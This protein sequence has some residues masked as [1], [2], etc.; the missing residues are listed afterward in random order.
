MAA[1]DKPV[2]SVVVAIVSDTTDRPDVTHL[3]PCLE[4][5]TKQAAQRPM[6][7]IVP[8]HPSVDGIDRMRLKYPDVRFVEAA[9]LTT[10]TGQGGSRE[11]HDELRARGLAAARGKIVA[12]IEDHGIVAPDWSARVL[13]AHAH[14]FAAIGGAI[15]NGIDQPL[16]WAVYFC[17]FLRYQ[18]PLPEGASAMAS[19]ANVSYKRAALESIQPVWKQIFHES[20]VNQALWARGEKIALAPRMVLEQHRLGLRMGAAMKERYVW[21]RSYAA[22]RARLAL[23]PSA[24]SGPSFRPCFRCS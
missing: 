14:S 21:G 18:N 15:E 24:R 13:E 9:K 1:P 3:D 8:Y 6:E 17:D 23:F 19:D 5:L 2:L 20:A 7:I 4:A 16:N 11:H 22:T 12:L 10:Y